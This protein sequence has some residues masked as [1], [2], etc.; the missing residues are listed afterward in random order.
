MEKKTIYSILGVLYSNKFYFFIFVGSFVICCCSYEV[1][2]AS[3]E[4]FTLS[5]FTYGRT[6]LKPYDWRYI[7]VDLPTWFSS[8]TISLESDIDLDKSRIMM[9]DKSSLPMICA[10]EGS[11]PLPDTH[12]TSFTGLVLAP[13]SNGSLAI[14][15]LQFSEKCYPMQKNILIKLTNEQISPGVWYFGLFNGIGS[16]RTQSK[17]INRGS[18]YSFSGNVTVEGCMSPSISGQFCNETIDHLSCVDQNSTQGIVTSCKSDGERSCIHQNESKLYSLDLL[19]VMEEITISATNVIFNQSQRS[20]GANNGSNIIL[21][22]YA[23]HGSISSPSTHDY[24]G[25]IN[26]A[27]LVI[28]SPKVGRWYITVTTLNVSKETAGST[29]VCYSLEWKLLQC[30]INKAGLNCTWER[31]TLQTIMR[32]NPSVPFESYYLPASDKVT[33]NSPNFPL[34]P[35]LSNISL[36]QSQSQHFAWTYFLVD[37][38]SGAS[39]GSI[40]IRLNSDKK[41]NHEIYA[42]YGGLPFE[43]KWDYFYAN[44]TSNSNG[45]M[46]FKLYDSDEKTISF[47]IVYVRGG[48]WSFGVKHLTSVGNA[49]KSQ[50][51]SQTTMSISIER[52]PR[53]CSSHGSCQNIVEMSGLS[54]YSYCWCDRTHGGFDCSVEIVSHQGHIW[55][56]VS[57]IASNAAFVFPAY[58]ALRQKA[59]A[60]WVIYT[61]SGISSGLYHACDVGTWCALSFRVL[62]FMDFWLSFMAVVSTFVYLADI[63]EGSKRTIHTVVAILTA[64][65]AENG[66]TRSSNIVLVIAI[67]AAGLLIGFLIEFF[68]HYRRFS[69]SAE[70]L[71]NMLHRW[72]TVKD[73]FHNLIKTIVKRFRWF[74]VVAGFGALAMAA[75]SWNLESTESYWFWHSMWHVSIYTSSFFFIFSKV[76]G[77]VNGE[78]PNTNYELTR[79]DSLSRGQ[80]RPEN[81]RVS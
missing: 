21:M 16:M 6:V 48:T 10:R 13:I 77:V 42:S 59:F 51:Q 36:G 78:P 22:C 44:S 39:G 47:Y 11:P 31:Y 63:D 71:L 29:D 33:S 26:N 12:N 35:L 73:W 34:E 27:P 23:R 65:M 72:Q 68:R 43:D 14:E 62:Q 76:N 1:H 2:A 69:F 55:Q 54:L 3:T 80:G 19:G 60:E 52:C 79:Q 24:S 40:H 50:S 28:R 5:S 81:G 58:W 41:I 32:K 46:F 9:A 30:P 75:I 56:S 18:G 7:R 25:N 17:M 8:V 53:R 64:L 37:I 45:S 20:N 61:S 15:G 49:L 70:L 38:P 74:F 66:P 4:S 57:L 67:G